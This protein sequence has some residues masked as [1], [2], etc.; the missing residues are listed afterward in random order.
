[1]NAQHLAQPSTP[2]LQRE[3]DTVL[4]L[5]RGLRPGV[6][7]VGHGRDDT[8]ITRVAAFAEAWTET[9][10]TVGAIVSWPASAASWLRQ[11][12]QLSADADTWVVADTPTGWA[13]IGPRLAET[14]LWRADRTVAFPGLD[15]PSLARLAGPAATEGL[16][17]ASTDG[18]TWH[19]GHGWLH[20]SQPTLASPFSESPDARTAPPRTPRPRPRRRARAWLAE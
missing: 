11:A 9:G 19:Y 6:V 8:S 15:D 14:G 3:L 17:G 10:G 5:V 1:M 20:T 13:G 12:R 18:G 7:N 16:H 4:R 2:Q